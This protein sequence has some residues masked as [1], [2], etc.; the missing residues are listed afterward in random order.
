MAELRIG[1]TSIISSIQSQS[2]S[3]TSATTNITNLQ[4]DVGTANTNIGTLQA[5]LGSSSANMGN[6]G[7]GGQAHYN[8][9]AGKTIFQILQ[10]LETQINTAR[11]EA[12]TGSETAAAQHVKRQT[13]LSALISGAMTRVAQTRATFADDTSGTGSAS[14]IAINYNGLDLWL[15][16]SHTVRS[17]SQN[18]TSLVI[19]RPTS[20]VMPATI[21]AW[22]DGYDVAFFTTAPTGLQPLQLMAQAW[23][24][25][26]AQGT[27]VY[28][29]GSP[30]TDKFTVT[31]GIVSDSGSIPDL[32]SGTPRTHTILDCVSRGG[33]S[34][35][36]II[37]NTGSI[38]SIA[39]LGAAVGGETLETIAWTVPSWA[40]KDLLRRVT[41]SNI[42]GDLTP[43]WIPEVD[44]V[45]L[46]VPNSGLWFGLGVTTL[47]NQVPDSIGAKLMQLGHDNSAVLKSI[48]IGPMTYTL[49]YLDGQL[50]VHDFSYFGANT[51]A[52]LNYSYVDLVSSN[53][54]DGLS[55]QLTINTN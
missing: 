49:G 39:R 55:L 17:S 8:M 27:E 25:Q 14:L 32:F 42:T 43:L 11:T 45:S 31:T 26:P 2:T 52:T 54:V 12:A 16:N 13:A 53:T 50:S 48:E 29:L 19:L 20:E 41:V 28:M 30:Y 9:G 33:N 35:G 38:V 47:T 34:G 37:D 4:N 15:T 23:R 24:E 51:A 6:I 46:S 40:I 1:G 44:I 5:C 18:A 36:P 7:Q 10:E 21:V 3:L 22:D